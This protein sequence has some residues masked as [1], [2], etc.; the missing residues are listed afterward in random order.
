MSEEDWGPDLRIAQNEVGNNGNISS[1]NP[2][3]VSELSCLT[4]S[5][6]KRSTQ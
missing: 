5:S 4:V 2:A 3:S 6:T 1:V